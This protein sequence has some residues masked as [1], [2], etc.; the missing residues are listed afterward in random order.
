MT[1]EEKELIQID[2]SARIPYGVVVQESPLHSKDE[3]SEMWEKQPHDYNIIGI[4]GPN[5]LIT[6]KTIT[7]HTYAKGY[8]SE[9]VTVC[10]Q[11]GLTHQV[12][13]PYLR[14]MLSMTD[15]EKKEYNSF[16]GGKQP[17]DS[18]FSA[19]PIEH[20]F[21]YEWDIK[22]YVDWLNEH[23]FDYRGLISKG[24]ALEAPEGMYD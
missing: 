6:D 2:I 13:L 3:I 9:P 23:H 7:K 11:N 21:V 18:D 15:D 17:F 5:T 19:Y 20:K 8:V 14:P 4:E 24:L 22:N 10:I 12:A 16:I 1:K